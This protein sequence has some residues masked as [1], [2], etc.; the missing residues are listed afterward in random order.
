MR[1]V[2]PLALGSLLLIPAAAFATSYS[3]VDGFSIATPGM[4]T[5]G[6]TYG[7]GTPSAGGPYT[8]ASTNWGATPAWSTRRTPP[9]ACR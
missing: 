8:V 6:W 5:S 3:A 9:T 2:S 1:F 4:G 7:S